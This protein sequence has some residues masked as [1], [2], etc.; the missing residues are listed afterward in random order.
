MCYL[1]FLAEGHV[2]LAYVIDG[3]E[4]AIVLTGPIVDR[5]SIQRDLAI[6][7]VF[8]PD[9]R[10]ASRHGSRLLFILITEISKRQIPI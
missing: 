6:W 7:L 4:F 8:S 1:Q 3:F 10:K 2:D 9:S 5:T